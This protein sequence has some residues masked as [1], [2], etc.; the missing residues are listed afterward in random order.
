MGDGPVP[1]KRYRENFETLS[2]SLPL[3]CLFLL[4]PSRRWLRQRRGQRR[5]KKK[6]L[7]KTLYPS[8]RGIKKNGAQ[9]Q[10]PP[11]SNLFPVKREFIHGAAV[12]REIR[13]RPTAIRRKLSPFIRRLAPEPCS[14]RGVLSSRCS[15]PGQKKLTVLNNVLHVR[16]VISGF[17]EASFSIPFVRIF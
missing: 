1:G 13:K 15:L 11:P 6:G 12:S 8:C 3:S 4:F 9:F 7:G 17:C 5:S 2:S 10:L 14:L 16:G